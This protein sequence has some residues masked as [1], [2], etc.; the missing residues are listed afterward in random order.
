[1]AIKLLISIKIRKLFK[2][3]FACQS[4]RHSFYDVMFYNCWLH[5]Q[6]QVKIRACKTIFRVICVLASYLAVCSV[7]LMTWL[8][9]KYYSERNQ[10][11]GASSVLNIVRT[12]FYLIGWWLHQKIYCNLP[13]TEFTVY[14]VSVPCEVSLNSSLN[15]FRFVYNFFLK[16]ISL[17]LHVRISS[18]TKSISSPWSLREISAKWIIYQNWHL[19]LGYSAKYQNQVHLRTITIF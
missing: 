17:F 15:L 6:W 9:N 12:F 5:L 1:M 8:K 18:W 19:R 16:K 10:G 2:N 14:K 13:I 11:P 7:F 4:A 3:Q